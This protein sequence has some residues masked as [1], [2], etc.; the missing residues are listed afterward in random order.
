M[1]KTVLFLYLPVAFTLLLTIFNYRAFLKVFDDFWAYLFYFGAFFI[2]FLAVPVLLIL[3]L[4]LRPPTALRGLGF[5]LGIVRHGWGILTA[6]IPLAVLIAYVG[7]RD[8][9]LQQHYPFSKTACADPRRFLL[10]ELAYVFFYYFPWEFL[11]RGLL[12]FPVVAALGL[13]AALALQTIVSTL[14]HVGHPDSEIWA[15]LAA[16]IIFGLIAYWT[17]SFL[18]ALLLHALIGVGNDFFLYRRQ[19]GR[20]GLKAG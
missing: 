14:L 9:A 13:P 19:A 3:T 2:F 20:R 5:T 4:S 18:Y 7:S 10:F 1:L 12:F 8:P 15:A 16:G 6:G 11:F 17:G